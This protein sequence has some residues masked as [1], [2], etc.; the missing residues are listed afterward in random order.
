MGNRLSMCRRSAKRSREFFNPR[1]G[2]HEKEPCMARGMMPDDLFRIQWV[3]DA[4]LSPDGRLVAF[5]VTRLDQEA[6]DYRSAIWLGSVDGSA[7]PRRFTGGSSKDST[8]RW[9]PDG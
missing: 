1:G 5:T 3:S 8:P 6:D 7:P 2:C 4:R 9:S